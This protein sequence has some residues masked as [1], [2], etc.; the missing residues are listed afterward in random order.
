MLL[1]PAL[2]ALCMVACSETKEENNEFS[3]W[4]NR[5]DSYYLDIYQR[6]TDNADGSWKLIRNYA[7]EDTIDAAA[8]DY[9]AV[10]VIEN[11]TGSGCPMFSD[12]VQ[13]NYDGRLIP[14]A[15]YPEGYVFEQ[16]YSGT[17]NP[18][19]AY[20]GKLYV[21]G[22]IDGMAT[23][24]QY[25]HIGDRWRIYI[26]YQMGYGSSSSSNV[27]A[28]STLIFDLTLVAYYRAGQPTTPWKAKQPGTWITE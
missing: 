12:S 10:Q 21:G 22:T 1:V 28:Y 4:Q 26:P 24:L 18:E 5:N 7:L 14:S 27:P 25:M 3:D 20:P 2:M 9:I 13:V 16:T 23:A 8:T 6:A 11:G 19:T 17:Y 15:S